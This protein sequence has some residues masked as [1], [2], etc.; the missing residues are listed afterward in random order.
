MLKINRC[1]DRKKIWIDLPYN[2]IQGE[3]LVTSSI[4]KL[5]RY[6]KENVKG[7]LMQI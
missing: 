3:Q 6:F 5:K 1:H 7:T 2:G 4:K